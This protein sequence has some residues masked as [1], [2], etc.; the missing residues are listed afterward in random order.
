MMQAL[1]LLIVEFRV[2]L[3]NHVNKITS[4]VRQICLSG[5][6]TFVFTPGWRAKSNTPSLGLSRL[7]IR[8]TR[9]SFRHR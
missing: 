6:W 9:V 4:R 1:I 8:I 3:L 2:G 5:F 7:V